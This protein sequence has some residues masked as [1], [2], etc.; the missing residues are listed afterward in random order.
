MTLPCVVGV[1]VSGIG[2]KRMRGV[3]L[4]MED[5]REGGGY[6][7]L[8]DELGPIRVLIVASNR[9]GFSTFTPLHPNTKQRNPFGI[10]QI[11]RY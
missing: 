7:L 6:Y 3:R 9:F 5:R 11:L 1:G 4:A 2:M 10:D 8:D